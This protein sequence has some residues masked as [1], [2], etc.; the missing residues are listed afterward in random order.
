[1]VDFELAASAEPAAGRKSC[2]APTCCL[3]EYF[4]EKILALVSTPEGFLR[5]RPMLLALFIWSWTARVCNMATERLIAKHRNSAPLRCYAARI[6]SSGF[7]TQIQGTHLASRGADCRAMT[8][9]RALKLGVPLR[10]A[11]AQKTRR[12]SVILLS[13][14]IGSRFETGWQ[15]GLVETALLIGQRCGI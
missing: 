6:L 13:G 14:Q 10:V 1:M 11:K 15:A 9:R 7:L 2:Y 3:D 5:H 8:R 4:T 12:Y